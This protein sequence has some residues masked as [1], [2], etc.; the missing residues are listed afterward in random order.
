MK[1]NSSVPFGLCVTASQVKILLAACMSCQVAELNAT[2]ARQSALPNSAQ[3]PKSHVI[4]VLGNAL[5]FIFRFFFP[6]SQNIMIEMS[7]YVYNDI[8]CN[9]YIYILV[10]VYVYCIGYTSVS[11]CISSIHEKTKKI[12]TTD[13]QTQSLC[14][15]CSPNSRLIESQNSMFHLC[16][17]INRNVFHLH[18][19]SIAIISSSVWPT[20][21]TVLA[22][23]SN[24]LSR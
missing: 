4:I 23:L 17:F 3:T 13:R 11:K 19:A 22:S 8:K 10:C 21:S 5:L 16:G 9:L 2:P 6:G 7:E 20:L 12:R 15:K 14:K 1:G 24:V 18:H